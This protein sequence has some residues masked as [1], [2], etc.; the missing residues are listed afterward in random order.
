MDRVKYH[1]DK[2]R[3][4]D[5]KEGFTLFRRF[6]SYIYR[7]WKLGLA[8]LILGNLSM[9]LG[10]VNPYIGKLILDNGI[11]A[12]DLHYLIV[13]SL[14]AVTIFAV[15]LLLS[16]AYDYLKNYALV[17]VEVD[18][19]RDV[20]KRLK[21][22]SLEQLQLRPAASNLF[23]ITNDISGAS[24]IINVT[25]VHLI[26]AFL[27]VIFITAI[28]I[29]INPAILLIVLAYQIIVIIKM[30]FLVKRAEN[31]RRLHLQKTEYIYR[32]LN[33][34]FSHIYLIKAF[35][36]MGREIK[37]YMHSFFDLMKLDMRGAR[38]RA[39]TGF[40]AGLSDKLFFGILVFYGSFLVIKGEMTLGTMGAI[41]LYI[42]QGVGAYS[43][44]TN[45]AGQLV[46]NKV[47]LE[48]VASL[49]DEPLPVKPK[50]KIDQLHPE[51]IR[52]IVFEDVVF[53][54][55]PEMEILKDMNFTIPAGSDIGLVGH[56][57]CG[58]TTLLSLILGLYQPKAGKILIADKLI[59]EI[60]LQYL[61]ERIGI[62]L[63]EPS[64]FADTIA[65]NISYALKKVSKK[66][67]IE[68]ATQAQALDFINSL[69]Q[70]FDTLVGENAYRL[71]QGQKQ[72]VSIARALIKKPQILILDEAM[73][74]LDSET[75][76][77]IIANIKEQSLHP[78][79]ILVSHRLS[80]VKEM[81][82]IYYFQKSNVM[83]TGKHEV[84]LERLPGY[85]QFFKAQL[86]KLNLPA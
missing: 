63:Q 14:L 23:R 52:K 4:E 2:L 27:K 65:N 83:H 25:L 6:N 29:F 1:L 15:S 37:K 17:K 68:A 64:L 69:P 82:L 20:F 47:S 26:N 5:I 8:I 38:L 56:S 54:Y 33:D 18:L 51:D 66:D 50:T 57:G 43:T 11:L 75:E 10:L 22:R 58:K 31:I 85:R 35:A 71:S 34:F 3:F 59:E 32:L 36:T 30:K 12:K 16:I 74:S 72:R 55:Q 44:L 86:D 7:Y 9:L 60:D 21:K 78:T 61:L 46:L 79:I 24:T 84:L 70:G 28:I 40:A 39:V 42:S 80:T 73:N 48:R 13:F 53:G 76:A 41:L 49:L 67:I 77:K 45:M 81:D 62:V 19:S